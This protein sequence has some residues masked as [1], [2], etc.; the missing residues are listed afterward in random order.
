MSY[1]TDS[2]IQSDVVAELRADRSIAPENIGVAVHR[3]VVTLSGIVPQFAQKYAA[4]K[5]ALRVRGVKGV[6]EQIEVHFAGAPNRTDTD[7][8]EAATNALQWHVWTGDHV[9]AKVENGWVTLTGDVEFPYQR[10]AAFNCVRFITGVKGVTS[11]IVLN[12]RVDV[13]NVKDAIEKAL[14]RDAELEASNIQVAADG[15]KVTLRGNVHSGWERRAASKAA[16]RTVGVNLVN[17]EL[18]VV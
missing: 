9:K 11:D 5:A 8:A 17:N 12:A 6:A 18:E 4:E 16:W 13:A 10:D 7:I 2:Q 1:K 15:G 3:G 14:V